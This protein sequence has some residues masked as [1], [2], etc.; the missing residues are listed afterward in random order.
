MQGCF[1]HT[2]GK[3][4][5]THLLGYMNPDICLFQSQCLMIQFYLHSMY[6]VLTDITEDTIYYNKVSLNTRHYCAC[7][8]Y[9]KPWKDKDFAFSSV[10]DVTSW[11]ISPQHQVVMALFSFSI[12]NHT[13]TVSWMNTSALSFTAAVVNTTGNPLWLIRPCFWVSCSTLLSG[14]DWWGFSRAWVLHQLYSCS[15]IWGCDPASALPLH[16]VRPTGVLL[17]LFITAGPW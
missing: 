10:S 11:W 12:R 13:W 6:L 4:G 2:V 9:S 15:L 17:N 5:Q 16:H 7:L 8:H 1:Q 3:N 14:T